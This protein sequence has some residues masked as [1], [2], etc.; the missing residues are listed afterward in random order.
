M[1][2]WMPGFGKQEGN[3]RVRVDSVAYHSSWLCVVQSHVDWLWA[4]P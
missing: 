1:D 3:S 2:V 4:T